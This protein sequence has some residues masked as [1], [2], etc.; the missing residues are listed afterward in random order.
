MPCTITCMVQ[1]S[2]AR[3]ETPVLEQA[4]NQP[5]PGKKK[6]EQNMVQIDGYGANPRKGAIPILFNQKKDDRDEKRLGNTD[7]AHR[8]AER[9][10]ENFQRKHKH[11]LT[12]VLI[13]TGK[14]RRSSNPHPTR[15]RPAT[16]SVAGASTT[17]NSVDER[18]HRNIHSAGKSVPPPPPRRNDNVGKTFRPIPPSKPQAFFKPSPPR[19]PRP[20]TKQHAT[21]NRYHRNSPP[22]GIP[23]R[24]QRET[25]S[26]TVKVSPPPSKVSVRNQ[27]AGMNFRGDGKFKNAVESPDVRRTPGWKF[28]IKRSKS[29][30]GLK[31][32]SVWL[33][34]KP[35]RSASPPNRPR[36]DPANNQWK[37][38]IAKATNSGA[39]FKK[40]IKFCP[41]CGKRIGPETRIGESGVSCADCEQEF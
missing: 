29:P 23:L 39:R 35:V 18:N 28:K 15:P 21:G 11:F 12:E 13:D 16:V 14:M 26:S 6:Q 27:V 41:E 32:N 25:P 37:T 31:A 24:Y 9:T 19:E 30:S 4:Y 33:K 5:R 22:Q 7:D 20:L 10:R 2:T 3:P 40:T 36:V 1:A 17:M 34:V 8:R 38:D